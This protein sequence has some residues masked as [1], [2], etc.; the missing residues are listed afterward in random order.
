MELGVGELL[1]KGY[2][3]SDEQ[4]MNDFEY[5]YLVKNDTQQCPVKMQRNFK[6][7][8]AYLRLKEL[9]GNFFGR[10]RIYILELMFVFLYFNFL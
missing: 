10:I 9:V 8:K 1:V 3:V 6:E 5:C 7:G 4:G 2:K